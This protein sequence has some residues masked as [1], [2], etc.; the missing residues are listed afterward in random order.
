MDSGFQRCKALL[1][2][3]LELLLGNEED[4]VAGVNSCA[5]SM[6]LIPVLTGVEEARRG[7]ILLPGFLGLLVPLTVLLRWSNILA[8]DYM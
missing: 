2:L 1:E 7:D 8:A 6:T 3:L 4:F 5:S